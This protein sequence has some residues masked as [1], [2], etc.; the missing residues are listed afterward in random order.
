[1]R[2]HRAE[3]ER[4]GQG[5]RGRGAPRLGCYFSATPCPARYCA[6]LLCS[7]SAYTSPRRGPVLS[8]GMLLLLCS[9][10]CGT[11]LG[12]GATRCA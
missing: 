3:P 9:A 8:E 1:M 4:G 6:V 5:T 11:E 12:Y 10:M 2:G 7:L